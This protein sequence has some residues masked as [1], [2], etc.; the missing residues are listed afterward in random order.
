ML[1][2]G[3]TTFQGEEGEGQRHQFTDNGKLEV[4][5]AGEGR[6]QFVGPI[7]PKAGL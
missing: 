7:M 4:K 2:D 1:C 3:N 6:S 5:K